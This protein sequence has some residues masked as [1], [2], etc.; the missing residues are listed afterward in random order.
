[1]IDSKPTNSAPNAFVRTAR[2]IYNPLGFKKGYNFL[3][4]MG[5]L[6]FNQTIAHV[7]LIR[8]H[9]RRSYLRLRT[10]SLAISCHR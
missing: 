10:R 6:H 9:L 4:C 8:V 2:K 7:I 5:S 3:L 1:M